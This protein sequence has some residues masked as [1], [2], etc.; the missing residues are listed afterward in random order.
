[1]PGTLVDS[2][3][4][5]DVLED[6][7]AWYERSAAALA[8]AASSGPMYIDSVIYA[9]V[10]VG[11][12]RIEELEE[13]VSGCGLVMAPIPKEALFLAAKAFVRYRT[14]GG[15]RPVPL[16]DFFIGAHAAVS[17]FD[18]LTRDPRSV[19]AYFPTVALISP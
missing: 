10:S 16:P 8:E 4:I 5:L 13:A 6:D 18:L 9:E 15:V 19:R 12:A 7:P 17:G 11:F 1:M 14:R 3:V 2:S